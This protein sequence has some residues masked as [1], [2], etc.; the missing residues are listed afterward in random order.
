MKALKS[1]KKPFRNILRLDIHLKVWTTSEKSLFTESSY[2][3]I[4]ISKEMIPQDVIVKDLLSSAN[5]LKSLARSNRDGWGIGYYEN[6]EIF[7]LKGAKSAE[8]DSQYDKAVG[9]LSKANTNIAVAHVRKAISGC[10]GVANP[11]P[12]QRNKGGKNWLFGHNGIIGKDQL[13]SII[14]DEYLKNNP[15]QTCAD[16]P[17]NSWVGSEL[18]FILLLKNIEEN[19]WDV[20]EGLRKAL[21]MLLNKFPGPLRGFNFFLTDGETIWAFRKGRPLYYYTHPESQYSIV[22]SMFPEETQDNW[23][24]V[25]EG[26]LVIMK[27]GMPVELVNISAPVEVAKDINQ[28]VENSNGQCDE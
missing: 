12:F 19:N 27:Q 25:P 21:N 11:H 26:T 23:V 1:M 5:S 14:G 9:K 13:I 10:M 18:Y 2:I 15:P 7:I 16:N 8:K 24:E 20:E 22:A 28:P 6:G 4:T 3:S 17:P